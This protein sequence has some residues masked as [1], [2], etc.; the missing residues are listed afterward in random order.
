M[1][2]KRIVALLLALVMCF[3]LV[4]CG[5][6]G[7]TPVT[8]GDSNTP[9]NVPADNN[10]G[11]TPAD[12]EETPAGMVDTG[13]SYIYKDSVSTL[14]SNWNPHTYQTTDDAYLQGYID[15]SL[16]SLIF[17][18]EN[19]PVEGKETFD[20]YTIVPAMAAEMPV[21][22]TEE[23][24][25]EYPQ[26]GIPDSATSSYAWK[27]KLRDDLQWDDGTPITAN[28][29]VES[30]KRLLDPKLLNFRAA[31]YSQGSYV[32]VNAE[33][34]AFQ[35]SSTFV[36]GGMTSSELLASGLTEDEI[37]IDLANFWG[38]TYDDGTTY[39]CITD[40]T[41]IRDPAVE[42]GQPEDY[43]SPKYLWD[44]Y[45]APGMPYEAYATDYVGTLKTYDDNY[46]FSNVGLLATDD[47][48]LIFVYKNAL[49]GFY[50]TTYG[51]STS[52]LVKTDLYDDCLVESESAA[53]TVYSSTYFT[54]VDTTAS[55]GPYVLSDYQMDKSLHLVKNPNWA[56][57]NYEW[58]NYVHPD[59]GETYQMY[60]TTEID[61][62]V[63]EEAT[64]RKQMFLA[65]QLMGYGLQAEDFDQY[66]NSDYCY[67][68]PAETIFFLL[69]N[70]YE[71]V[72]NQREAA[73]DFDATTHDLQMQMLNTFRRA[74]AVAID[75]EDLAATCSPSRQGGY[76]F[77]GQTYIYDPET[78]A[79]YRDTDPAK[80]AL[81]AFYSVNVD[82]FGG[83]LDA[84]VASI[85]GYDAETAKELFQ[86]AYEE[87]IEL[88]YITDNNGDGVSDQ[89]VNMV[90]AL[91]AESE[92]YD[93]LIAY[94]TE[95]F[96]KATEGTG[97][98]QKI[99]ITK[100]APLG[101]GWSDG[102][103]NGLYDTQLA[104]WSGA[105]L[106]PFSMADTWTRTDAAYWGQ[107]WDANA[108]NMTVNIN[109][110]DLTMSIR[111]FA[112]CLNGTM[113]TVDGVDYNFGYGQID[114]DTRLEI[115]A[116]I[117][118]EMLLSYN[119]VPIMQ[120]A[121]A[122]LLSQQVYN[123]VEDYN[124]MMGRGGIAYMRYNYTEDEWNEYVA[125]QGG[126]LQ[127]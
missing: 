43:V 31:D 115:L 89:E 42:E 83:D 81:C 53:G 55:Y 9:A 62:Q 25:A 57:W 86:E 65:G 77:L 93:K 85:T 14:A 78:C 118:Q 54:G 11:E 67:K 87:G 49:E 6:N 80:R 125:S 56:G 97:L 28:D 8:S 12:E 47:N 46:D 33:N 71:D 112:E 32:V 116:A 37:Y 60:E 74:C 91:S 5:D 30:F 48:S 106:D 73:A 108:H 124:P 52:W 2:A 27:V 88:G 38:I 24:K 92:L 7:G 95:S 41:M 16:Y 51:M 58:I 117:E 101:N 50:L 23:I 29:F 4:A 64:T 107:W 45:F 17:N 114:T 10:G 94:F 20:G 69:F 76:G 70:G 127:Y 110:K 104:G 66:I 36:A 13:E 82:D 61:C 98:Y 75:R 40:D 90:Y 79:Y 100:S 18:D 39:G 99:R 102:I 96:D 121:G 34:Y 122:S 113:K 119:C 22:V 103:R 109:G 59:D 72:I 1:T 120:D 105:T 123:V 44:N 35:G 26:F 111:A 3:A 68:T 126:T 63:V 19:H 21:D 84:A 15:D